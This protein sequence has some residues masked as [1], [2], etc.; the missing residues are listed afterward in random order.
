MFC[1]L[2]V[3][4]VNWEFSIHQQIDSF[5]F[6]NDPNK[7]DDFTLIQNEQMIK[8]KR[9]SFFHSVDRTNF[10]IVWHSENLCTPQKMS[11]QQDDNETITEI[12]RA[13]NIT[14][15]EVLKVWVQKFN[16]LAENNKIPLKRFIDAM[17]AFGWTD[18]EHAQ[19]IF[20]TF[21]RGTFFFVWFHLLFQ[22]RNKSSECLYLEYFV[23]WCHDCEDNSGKLTIKE[24]IRMLAVTYG[25]TVEQK[26]QASFRLFDKNNNGDIS[27]HEMADMLKLVLR[28]RA[29][30]GS[31][32]LDLF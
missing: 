12:A 30:K 22:S 26:L 5:S 2:F 25:G 19:R 1:W 16:T 9:V 8:N 7:R 24:W 15:K 13:H 20:K 17:T 27:K 29:R 3:W 21:D 18:V 23:C 6:T 11:A 4:L 32:F 31:T 28:L 10:D 14:D